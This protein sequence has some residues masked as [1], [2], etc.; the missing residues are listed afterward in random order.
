MAV[1]RA[2]F[3]ELIVRRP[4][5]GGETRDGEGVKLGIRRGKGGG[6]SEWG[7]REMEKHAKKY[8]TLA[9]VHDAT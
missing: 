9:V 3:A 4:G 8:T 7:W 6:T 1:A 5:G 2:S